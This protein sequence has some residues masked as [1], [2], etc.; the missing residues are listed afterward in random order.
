ML[1]AF[2]AEI[3]SHVIQLGGIPELALELS[4]DQIAAIPE[5]AP[6]RCA[7]VEIQQRM[8]E[9]IDRRREA[10]DTLGGIFEVVVRGLLP[11]L[12]SHT[13]WDVKLTVVWPAVMSIRR[14]GGI[15]P[16]RGQRSSWSEIHDEIAYSSETKGSFARPI[17]PAGSS[18]ASQTAKKCAS[19]AT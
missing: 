9:S 7:D 14:L 3:R 8:I 6:L 11:G 4:W 17:E 15:G 19:A 16:H 12:G 13:A 2:G 18:A 1:A 5:D 10:G